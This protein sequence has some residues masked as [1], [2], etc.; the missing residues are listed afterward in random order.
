MTHTELIKD[1][2]E[3]PDR[4]RHRDLNELTIC[5]MVNGSID[6]LAWQAHEGLQGRN[7]GKGCDVS[8]GPCACGAWH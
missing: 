6:S 5:C 7:G 3:R 8:S 2:Q 4:H 1:I